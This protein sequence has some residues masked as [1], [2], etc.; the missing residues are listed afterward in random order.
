VGTLSRRLKNTDAN[1]VAS[2]E[3]RLNNKKLENILKSCPDLGTFL[4]VV[5][6]DWGKLQKA[7]GITAGIQIHIRTERLAN[8]CLE[9]YR[10]TGL[11]SRLLLTIC[12]RECTRKCKR[13]GLYARGS[14]ITVCPNRPNRPNRLSYIMRLS[15]RAI[16]PAVSRR[17]PTA[18]AQVRPPGI[19]G[20]Q[21]G[22]GADFLRVFRVPLP[23]IIPPTAPHSS[24][25]IRGWYNR[26]ISGRRTKWTQYHPTTRN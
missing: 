20:G 17:F 22:I 26:P 11:F 19:C 23:I 1:C 16:A 18:A 4:A 3:R 5:R 21:S 10:N 25:I 2:N 9:P 8:T 13:P 24:T 15:G 7:S 6:R 14:P 12:W